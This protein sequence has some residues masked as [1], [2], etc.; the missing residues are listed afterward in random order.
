[1]SPKISY[2][3]ID[4]VWKKHYKVYDYLG[5]LRFTIGEDKALLNYKQYEPYGETMLDTFGLT[6]QSYIGKEKEP[7]NNLG[8]H[9]VRKYDYETGRF[10]SIDPL[11]EKYY[12]W[13]P[14]QY[15]MNNPIIFT[16]PSGLSTITSQKGEVVSVVDDNDN[17]IYRRDD[18]EFVGPVIPGHGTTKMGQTYYWDEFIN[19]ETQ[20][21]FGKIEFGESWEN[22][23]KSK[24]QEAMSYMG[25]LI[26]IA[27]ESLPGG[28]LDIK[29]QNN[30]FNKGKMIGGY[31]FSGRSAGNWLA[32]WNASTGTLLGAY[33]SPKQVFDNLAGF[34]DNIQDGR[35]GFKEDSYTQR[36]MDLGWKNK[37]RF[38]LFNFPYK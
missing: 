17:S 27:Y 36:V 10:N 7:E 4:G 24:N 18:D 16:D 20:R 15:S 23:L 3:Y 14:Y 26:S 8:D 1:M 38:G 19:P 25:G 32:G 30:N 11:F 37:G 28:S 5:S 33:K 22:T 34:L 13:S 31:Y 9:G 35:F 12:G 29:S 2:K 6:R 21:V